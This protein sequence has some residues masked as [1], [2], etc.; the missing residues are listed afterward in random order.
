[1]GKYLRNVIHRLSKDLYQ[2]RF[3]IPLFFLYYIGV[4]TVFSAFCPAV[5]ITGFPCPG[6]GLTRAALYLARGRFGDAWNINPMIFPVFAL[7]IYFVVMR[8]ILGARVKGFKA[9]LGVLIGSMVAVY[10]YRMYRYFPNRPPLSFTGGSVLE[11][12]LPGYGRVIR[13]LI[14]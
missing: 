1:M 2:M 12:F 6:C 13:F 14:Y 4:K 10:I 8:Y 9:L 5:I 7:G 11:E 3:V